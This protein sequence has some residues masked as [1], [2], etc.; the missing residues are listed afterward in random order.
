MGLAPLGLGAPISASDISI[1]FRF[2]SI[3]TMTTMTLND[4]DE[5]HLRVPP[6][7]MY[8]GS[9]LCMYTPVLSRIV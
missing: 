1:A 4:V 8:Y 3:Y 2:A 6:E 7:S 5:E 9:F